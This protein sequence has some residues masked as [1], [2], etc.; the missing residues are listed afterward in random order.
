MRVRTTEG[1]VRFYFSATHTHTRHR[2][3]RGRLQR[4]CLDWVA[5]FISVELVSSGLVLVVGRISERYCIRVRSF[6]F[7]FSVITVLAIV[8]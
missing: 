7:A 4:L 3:L 2:T 5:W 1:V 6:C 8:V